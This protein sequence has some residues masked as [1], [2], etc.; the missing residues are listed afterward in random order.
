M[1]FTVLPIGLGI[2][3]QCPCV[4][5]TSPKIASI[6]PDKPLSLKQKAT[7]S[8]LADCESGE[9]PAAKK[10]NDRFLFDGTREEIKSFVEEECPQ[11]T[12]KNNEWAVHNFEAWHDAK[13]K[14]FAEDLCPDVDK[15]FDDRKVTCNGSAGMC[16]EHKN[17]LE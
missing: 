16:Q 3:G 14:R 2:I 4:N 12:T 8:K 1:S 9:E 7:V 13:I 17:Q 6:N 5:C 15:L 10:V 11:D